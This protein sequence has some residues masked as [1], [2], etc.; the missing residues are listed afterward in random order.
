MKKIKIK[1]CNNLYILAILALLFIII[2]SMKMK[3]T[4]YIPSPLPNDYIPNQI[5]KSSTSTSQKSVMYI[6]N[7][8]YANNADKFTDKP[9]IIS[10]AFENFDNLKILL[11]DYDNFIQKNSIIEINLSCPNTETDIP[12]YDNDFI[13]KLLLF[14]KECELQNIKFG[15]KLPPYLQNTSQLH[16][17]HVL[18]NKVSVSSS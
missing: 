8:W 17:T 15:L 10:I 2:I 16:P 4:Y 7:T 9:Y 3:E 18:I 5:E 13:N 12:G 11:D 14:L 1:K 6:P